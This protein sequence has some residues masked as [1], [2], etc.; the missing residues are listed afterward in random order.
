VA[1]QPQ[2]ET[3]QEIL[4]WRLASGEIDAKAYTRTCDQLAGRQPGA[5]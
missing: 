1:A 4:D 5:T 2:R 3:P